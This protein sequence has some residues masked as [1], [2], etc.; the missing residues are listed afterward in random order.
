MPCDAGEASLLW[1]G[2][3]MK[4]IGI[5]SC[6][7]P[8]GSHVQSRLQGFFNRERK[9]VAVKLVTDA[10]RHIVKQ[11]ELIRSLKRSRGELSEKTIQLQDQIIKTQAELVDSKD[12]TMKNISQVVSESVSDSV[13][14][15]KTYSAAVSSNQAP[16]C[17]R[18]IQKAV[19]AVIEEEDRAKNLIVFGLEESENE[20]LDETVGAVFEELGEKPMHEDT[21]IGKK[22]PG[23]TRPVKVKLRNGAA[24]LHLLKKS[25]EL[26]KSARFG[27]VFLCPDRS[28]E[29]RESQRKLVA[30]LRKKIEDEPHKSHVIRDGTIVSRIRTESASGY[31]S[32]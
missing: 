6:F 13:K 10:W 31:F 15:I 17:Q 29:E 24:A 20:A 16:L 27:R 21:R 11:N 19:K 22:K 12:N 4:T 2:E 7:E 9:D 28:E 32:T 25:S 1:I 18:T 8:E 23:V 14:E 26:K 30:E 5:S 3:M